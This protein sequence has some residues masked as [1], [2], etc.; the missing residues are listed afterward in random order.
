MEA[1]RSGQPGRPATFDERADVYAGGTNV[2]PGG[3]A[4]VN[5]IETEMVTFYL[6]P[7]G[8]QSEAWFAWWIDPETGTLM[9]A[10]MIAQMHFMVWDFTDINAPIT[11]ESPPADAVAT[12]AG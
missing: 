9:R 7:K 10:V 8:G 4:T 3:I 11:I 5:G 12:S 2:V 6:P 1:G